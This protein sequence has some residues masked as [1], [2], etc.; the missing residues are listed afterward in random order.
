ML[1]VLFYPFI[2]D[3]ISYLITSGS[4]IYQMSGAEPIRTFMYLRNSLRCVETEHSSPTS[5]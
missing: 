3:E 2:R 5:V 1:T 4:Q